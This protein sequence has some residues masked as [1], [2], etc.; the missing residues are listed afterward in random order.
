[1]DKGITYT[2]LIAGIV[3]IGVGVYSW[4]T[5][6]VIKSKDII[7]N[8]TKDTKINNNNGSEILS[9]KNICIVT[10]GSGY[11]CSSMFKLQAMY[12]I[13]CVYN[14]NKAKADEMLRRLLIVV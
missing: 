13:V 10:G 14:A 4:K 7:N 11:W 1:M 8:Y 2:S 12:K 9:K 3:G 5:K 6:K